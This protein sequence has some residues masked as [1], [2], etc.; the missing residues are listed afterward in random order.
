MAESKTRCKVRTR[1]TVDRAGRGGASPSCSPTCQPQ[2]QSHSSWRRSRIAACGCRAGEGIL[3]SLSNTWGYSRSYISKLSRWARNNWRR[4]GRIHRARSSSTR[5][6]SHSGSRFDPARHAAR[7]RS[8]GLCRR[9]PA[10]ASAPPL[11][12]NRCGWPHPRLQGFSSSRP[13]AARL[14]GLFRSVK[15]LWLLDSNRAF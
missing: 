12:R 14:K 9:N 4:I 6:R 2:W 3:V 8:A 15:A 7:A 11:R 5:N 1:A 10:L 13:I